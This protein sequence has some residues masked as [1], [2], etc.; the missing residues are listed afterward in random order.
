MVVKAAP[1][2][3][4]AFEERLRQSDILHDKYELIDGEMVEKMPNLEHAFIDGLLIMLL[5]VFVRE[6]NLGWVLPELRVK[7]PDDLF[8]ARQPDIAFVRA[9]RG[10][11]DAKVA[12]PV[13]P[14]LLIEIKSPTDTYV[15]MRRKA[16][17]YL[18]NGA[19]LVWLIF[20]EK[21]QIEVHRADD[22]IRTLGRGDTLTGDELLPGFSVAVSEIFRLD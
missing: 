14:D 7:L 20:P 8:N 3:V 18:D 15:Q 16:L 17:Y 4:E 6:H 5:G 21:A 9:G 19:L 12:F 2:T 10:D 1:M 11:F 22:V 13:M